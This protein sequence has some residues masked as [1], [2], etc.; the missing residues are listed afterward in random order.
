VGIGSYTDFLIYD[1]ANDNLQVRKV[2]RTNSS[3]ERAFYKTVAKDTKI[4]EE[5]RNGVGV[6]SIWTKNEEPELLGYYDIYIAATVQNDLGKNTFFN[7]F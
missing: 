5:L 6:Y 7:S 3:I 1:S 4:V 2:Q